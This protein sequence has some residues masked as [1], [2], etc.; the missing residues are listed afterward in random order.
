MGLLSLLRKFRKQPSRELR[1]LILGLDNAG[2]TTVLRVLASEQD[3][4]KNTTPTQGFNVKSV[5]SQG[6]KLN[7]WDIGGQRTIRPYWKHYFEGT[8]VLIFVVDSAD[9]MRMDETGEELSELLQEHKLAG[10][11]LLVFANKQ[12]LDLAMPPDEPAGY[13][14]PDLQHNLL[15]FPQI[16]E[17]FQLTSLTDRRWQIQPC[18]A[19]RGEGIQEGMDWMAKN[20]STSK[21]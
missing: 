6:F 19:L 12:D 21:W 3:E 9:M 14:S 4:I 17:K 7:I 5:H 18:S 16:A 2:K 20:V 11:P 1:I 8:D 10:V 13:A 15:I